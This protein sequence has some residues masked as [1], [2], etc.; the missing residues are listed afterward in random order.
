[1][2]M[3]TEQQHLRTEREGIAERGRP[4]G[5]NARFV[6]GERLRPLQRRVIARHPRNRI[7]R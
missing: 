6:L 2:T 1:M 7:R 5:E 4:T 3:D